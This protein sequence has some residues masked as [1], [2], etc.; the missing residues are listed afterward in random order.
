VKNLQ[1]VLVVDPE[2]CTGCQSCEMA[3]SYIKEKE[4]NSLNSR[5]R[6]VKFESLGIDIPMVCQHCETPPCRDICPVNAIKK[7]SDGAVLIGEACIGCKSCSLVC[8]YGVIS[9]DRKRGRSIKCDLCGGD[10]ECVKWCDTGAIQYV[11][12]DTADLLKKRSFAEKI[13]KSLLEARASLIK[14]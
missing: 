9:I 13:M 1:K 8:P 6:V 10:P 7:N 3:C 5:I 12:A 14:G 11:R 2:K 4:F